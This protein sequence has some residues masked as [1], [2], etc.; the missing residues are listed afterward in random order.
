[1]RVSSRTLP[2]SLVWSVIVL[3]AMVAGGHAAV[4]DEAAAEAWPMFRGGVAG[5][6][7][8]AARI[9]LPAA[10]TNKHRS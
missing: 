5:S 8:S 7:R 10:L 1:M 4:G 6:G 9:T 3:V 2:R